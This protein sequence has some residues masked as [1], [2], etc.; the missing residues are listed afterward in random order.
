LAFAPAPPILPQ[1]DD[2]N[3]RLLRERVRRRASAFNLVD[4]LER[5]AR[6]PLK[7]WGKS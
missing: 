2:K 6:A 3:G 7:Q 5:G 4:I 1:D